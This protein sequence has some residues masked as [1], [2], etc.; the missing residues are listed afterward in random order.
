MQRV[1]IIGVVIW[2]VASHGWRVE[3]LFRAPPDPELNEVVV[4][5]TESC[6][7][8]ARTLDRL[9]AWALDYQVRDIEQSAAARA[10]FEALGGRG[11]PLVIVNDA[12]VHGHDPQALARQ[13]RRKARNGPLN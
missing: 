3:G 10:E 2:I 4:Y 12:L 1:L 6:P 7:W 13:L 8:C 9:D 11:V 5:V